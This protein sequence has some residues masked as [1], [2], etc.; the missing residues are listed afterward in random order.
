[1]NHPRKCLLSFLLL[2]PTHPK[3]H[4][5]GQNTALW[6]WNF[7]QD[8][9][10]PCEQ[11]ITPHDSVSCRTPLRSNKEIDKHKDFL[12]DFISFS[13]WCGEALNIFLCRALL[14][15]GL[16]WGLDFD[17]VVAALWFFRKFSDQFG[18][19][20]MTDGLIFDLVSR[21]CGCKKSSNH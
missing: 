13:R 2:P 20:W 3:L 6:K 8:C 14:K 11:L 10:Q 4:P 9:M 18:S 16:G 19:F 15:P 7:I 17:W 1:M 12:Y 5:G 21:S